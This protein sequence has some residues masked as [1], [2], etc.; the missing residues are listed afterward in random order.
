MQYPM[1]QS[2]IALIL[3][4]D[5]NNCWAGCGNTGAF[6]HCWSQEGGE[7][8]TGALGSWGSSSNIE[9]ELLS[10]PEI[11]LLGI[12]TKSMKTSV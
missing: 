12:Y 1:T 8:G 2:S 10:D 11:P 7:T 3:E 5:N 4:T 6:V 9:T